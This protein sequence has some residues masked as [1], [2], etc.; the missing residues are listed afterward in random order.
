MGIPSNGALGNWKITAHSRLDS[1]SVD[2]NVS[3][4]TSKGITLQIEETEFSI[5]S[6]III[7]GIAVFRY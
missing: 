2:I 3:V 5:G 4:P 6:I 1:K 7:K